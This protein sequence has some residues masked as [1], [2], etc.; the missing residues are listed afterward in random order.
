MLYIFESIYIKKS[1]S[2]M[3]LYSQEHHL[4]ISKLKPEKTTTFYSSRSAKLFQLQAEIIF[5]ARAAL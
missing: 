4:P 1:D 3:H 5:Q 2:L